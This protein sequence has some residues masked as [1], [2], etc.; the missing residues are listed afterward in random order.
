MKIILIAILFLSTL[1]STTNV[2]TS[3]EMLQKVKKQIKNIST[4]ELQKIL[5]K[6]PQTFLIDVRTRADI[7]I[8]GGE[9]KALNNYNIPRG[10]LETRIGDLVKKNS[11]IVVYCGIGIRSA[12]ATKTLMDMGYTNVKNYEKGFEEWR[13]KDLPR[14]ELD[15][16]LSS[17]L[18]DKVQEVIKGVVYTSFGATA[19]A[20]YEN[21]GHNNNLSFIVTESG[22]V[23]F[24]AGASYLLAKALHEEIKNIT[25]QK[26]KYVVME[27]AQGHAALGMS[28]WNEVKGVT[29]IMHSLALQEWKHT[30]K[31]SLVRAK[32][33]QKDKALQTRYVMPDKTFD[34][35]MNLSMG[36]EKIII[37]YLGKAHGPGDIVLIMPKRK[38]VISGD[39]AFNERMLPVFKHT[40]IKEWIK[41]WEKFKALKP[42]KIIPGHGKVTNLATVT[43]FTIGYLKFLRKSIGDLIDNDGGLEDINSIDQSAYWDMDTFKELAMQNLATVF[44]RMEFE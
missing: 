35:T 16:Y 41:T 23:V 32:K 37:K 1:Q 25:N 17:V 29:T 36:E 44:K 6:N 19:P 20:N 13:N 5:K 14:R 11:P 26:V 31:K 39:V 18:Y 38:L 43:R 30:G 7:N 8:L 9:I 12:Y 40:Q 33:V 21:S 10:W 24:N 4:K 27:N 34:K 42:K 3:E 28:Y 2:K 15:K 22:V